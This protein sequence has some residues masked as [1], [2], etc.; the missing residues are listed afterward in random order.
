MTLIVPLSL[1]DEYYD[2]TEEL[3]YGT[4]DPEQ[5]ERLLERQE[6]IIRQRYEESQAQFLRRKRKLKAPPLPEIWAKLF[7]EHGYRTVASR[8]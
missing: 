6:A 7:E 8:S 4:L 1:A 2:L 3:V 5:E